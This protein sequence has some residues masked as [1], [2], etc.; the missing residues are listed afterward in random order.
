MVAPL[1]GGAVLGNKGPSA[2]GI[3]AAAAALYATL[4]LLAVTPLT[5][6]SFSFNKKK[7]KSL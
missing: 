2:L 5:S 3:V 1:V 6:T 7:V 4:P